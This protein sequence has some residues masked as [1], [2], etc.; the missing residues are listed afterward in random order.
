MI[1]LVLE[2]F[3]LVTLAFAAGVGFGIA[4][5]RYAM[6]SAEPE[7]VIEEQ[8]F[9]DTGE[10]EEVLSFFSPP[11]EIEAAP[12]PPVRRSIPDPAPPVQVKFNRRLREARLARLAAK[13]ES[14]AD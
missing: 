4:M 14:P 7:P 10:E 13:D 11:D 1:L 9:D 5:F 6:P 12:A 3:V 2:I 8:E